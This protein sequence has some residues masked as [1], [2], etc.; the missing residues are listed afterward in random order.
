MDKMLTAYGAKIYLKSG[1]TLDITCI[2]DGLEYPFYY[3]TQENGTQY[4]ILL[5]A[6]EYV[7]YA[8]ERSVQLAI[9][10]DQELQQ[11]Q[12]QQ[13]QERNAQC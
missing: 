5:D 7:E 12:Q 2:Y 10:R 3:F 1:K 11:Q 4:S 6:I 8:V 9:R 13:S